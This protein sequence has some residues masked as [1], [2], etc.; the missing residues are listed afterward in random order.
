MR[1]TRRDDPVVIMPRGVRRLAQPRVAFCGI[2]R[3][4]KRRNSSL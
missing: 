1:T 4:G 2:D 3:W